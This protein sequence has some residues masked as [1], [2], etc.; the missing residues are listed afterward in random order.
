M[1]RTAGRRY[2]FRATLCLSAAISF[3]EKGLRLSE[4]LV[5]LPRRREHRER[6]WQAGTSC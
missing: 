6:V 2:V 3:W 5:T 4:G 1:A